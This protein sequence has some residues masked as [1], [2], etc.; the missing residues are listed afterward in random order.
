MLA[1][2]LASLEREA[3]R[4]GAAFESLRS[5][6]RDLA[7]AQ[8]DAIERLASTLADLERARTRTGAA[9][10]DESS[11]RLEA[12]LSLADVQGLSLAADFSKEDLEYVTKAHNIERKRGKNRERLQLTFLLP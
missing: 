12:D 7:Q 4:I 11:M 8:V 2:D 6:V 10:G 3:A 5:L 1:D 9:A